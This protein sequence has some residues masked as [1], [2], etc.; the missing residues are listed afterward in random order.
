VPIVLS[1]LLELKGKTAPTSL[2][3]QAN[4]ENPDAEPRVVR[5]RLQLRAEH[6]SEIVCSETYDE[7]PVLTSRS[8]GVSGKTYPKAQGV[9]VLKAREE[10]DGRV[11]MELVPEIQYGD[12]RQRY[13]GGQGTLR[14]Q[15]GRAK[16][17]FDDLAASAL[18]TSGH[19]I[20]LTSIPDRPGSLGDYFFRHESEGKPEQ[21]LIV[22]RVCQTQHDDLVERPDAP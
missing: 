2:S 10:R 1:Q 22:I 20:V 7:L 21:K 12:A 6:P 15:F 17:S 5:R 4:F 11:K 18:L 16:Q 14:L 19:M 13:V 8:N 3:T 9:L